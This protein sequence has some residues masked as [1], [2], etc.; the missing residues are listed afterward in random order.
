MSY[1][2]F[3]NKGGGYYKA[4]G[5]HSWWKRN[6]GKERRS[7]KKTVKSILE[8]EF[9]KRKVEM[10]SHLRIEISEAKVSLFTRFGIM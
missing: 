9:F 4:C 2:F 3:P 6:C 1:S 5:A 7:K 10:F 8:K